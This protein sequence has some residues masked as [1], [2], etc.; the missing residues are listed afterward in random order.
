VDLFHIKESV[1]RWWHLMCYKGNAATVVKRRFFFMLLPIEKQQ[2]FLEEGMLTL[3]D[4][5]RATEWT[6]PRP[7][8]I[9][10]PTPDKAIV[11]N[12]DLEV[13]N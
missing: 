3:S 7:N 10:A 9:P 4:I 5:A 8:K 1:R 13:G 2:E 11:R 6:D 12:F